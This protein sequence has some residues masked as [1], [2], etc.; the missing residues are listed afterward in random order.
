MTTQLF[1]ASTAFGL[2]TAV[3]AVEDGLVDPADRRVL[4]MSNNAAVPETAHDIPDVAGTDVLLDRFDA[5]HS[6][7]ALVAPQHP[8]TWAPRDGDLPLWQRHWRSALQ[9]GSDRV[10]LV[11]ESIQANP[12]LALC[13]VFP[14]ARIDV[15]A[16]GLMSYGPTRTALPFQVGGRVRRLLHLDLVPGLQPLLLSEWGVADR[17]IGTEA[18]RRVVKEMADGTAAPDRRPGAYAVLLGQYLA[19]GGL[20]SVAEENQLHRLMVRAAVE[21]GARHLVFKPHPTSPWVDPEP[22]RAEAAGAGATVEIRDQPELVETWFERGEVDLVVG[23][24]STAMMTAASCYGVG[25]LQVGAGVLLDRLRPFQNSNRI[26]VTLVSALLPEAARLGDAPVTLP[27]GAGAAVQPLVDTVGYVMQPVLLADR[28]P[29]AGRFLA[30]HFVGH[31]KYFKRRRL[32]K[33]QLPGALPPPSGTDRARRRIR[34]T[35]R[36]VKALARTRGLLHLL[37]LLHLLQR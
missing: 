10:D 23:C 25:V 16:D 2:A 37:H 13:Q 18:F 30:E 17:P 28:R 27:A 31:R 34:R 1:C 15:Y 11:V 3:A 9:L 20:L 7:N 33:L 5:V 36:R 12:A 32:T 26:P 29:E 4:L 6:Y 8:A 24:F 21:T 22:L 19:S 35:G 14:D